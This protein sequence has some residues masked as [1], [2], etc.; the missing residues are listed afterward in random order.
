MID[1]RLAGIPKECSEKD[2]VGVYDCKDGIKKAVIGNLGGGF[3]ILNSD[4]AEESCPVVAPQYI[5]ETCKK[6][7]EE[8]Y[9]ADK[10]LCE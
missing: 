1:W 6:A 7:A 10:N 9:C 8:G 3:K 4:R 2:I 5:T